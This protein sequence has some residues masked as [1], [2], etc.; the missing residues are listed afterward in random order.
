M[1]IAKAFGNSSRLVQQKYLALYLVA[2]MLLILIAGCG[3]GS[4]SDFLAVNKVT[5]NPSG[6]APLSASIR[7]ESERDVR[8]RLRIAGQDGTASDVV[9]D[10]QEVGRQWDIPVHGLYADTVNIVELFFFSPEGDDLGKLAYKLHTPALNQ[11]LPA[12]TIERALRDQ[13]NPGMTLVS[14]YGHNGI[15]FPNRPFIFDSFGKIRWYLDYQEHPELG[16]LFYEDGVERLANGNFFFG[17]GGA[18]F[19]VEPNNRLYE[20]DMFGNI[21]NTWDMP[22]YG[23]H[24]EAF[25]LPDGN[26]LVTV[27]KLDVETVE[28]YLIEI[29]RES[30][31]IL[32]EWNLNEL[33][34]NKRTAWTN[35]GRDWFHANAV[36]TDP[37]D[38]GIVVSGRTQ[39]LVKLAA[40]GN[41]LE[42]ILAP[43][44]EWGKAGNGTDL[45]HYLLQPL[46]AEGKPITDPAVLQGETGHPDF[47]WSWYQHAPAYMPNGDL[48]LFDNGNNRDFKGTIDYSRAVIYHIDEEKRT[49][50]QRWAYGKERGKEIYSRLVGDV[51]YLQP[52]G[53]ILYTAGNVRHDGS[54]YGK[55]IEVDYP[56]GEVIFEATIR[57]PVALFDLVTLNRTER[58]SLYP[59]RKG[60]Q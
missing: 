2:V 10:F 60:N 26:F 17:S 30:K 59:D 18:E 46:D 53:H 13:M 47:E 23:F 14:Y 58:L 15:A 33:L 21:L 31:A 6:Y 49:I 56:S 25:E 40:D 41:E 22:G 54:W 57:P 38:Q 55:S 5:L 48:L 8:V 44:K 9:Q 42:W 20:I 3:G 28:D 45:K 1:L 24:H 43:H 29:D 32:R 19:G 36:L 39:A 12:V 35:D 34:D 50:S 7:L 4:P 27:N 37:S 52:S 11:A 16:K 51:D